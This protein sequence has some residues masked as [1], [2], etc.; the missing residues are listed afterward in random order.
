MSDRTQTPISRRN[1][2]AGPVSFFVCQSRAWAKVHSFT[3]TDLSRRRGARAHKRTRP[4]RGSHTVLNFCFSSWRRLSFSA[5]AI[6]LPFTI[7]MVA[8]RP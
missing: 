8:W 6:S 3:S 2:G 5:K 7:G 1:L 4:P